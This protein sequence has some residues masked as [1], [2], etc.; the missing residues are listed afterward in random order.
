MACIGPH[1]CD[2]FVP[3]SLIHAHMHIEYRVEPPLEVC[4]FELH[5]FGH[6][7]IADVRLFRS[8][9]QKLTPPLV[10]CVEEIFDELCEL[11]RVEVVWK[12]VKSGVKYDVD[13]RLHV[14]L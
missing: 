1:I 9:A 5:S 2:F 6:V 7:P 4:I 14:I 13:Q 3:H 11:V 10:G 12:V 8:P